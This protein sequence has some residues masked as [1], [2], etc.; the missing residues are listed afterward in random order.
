MDDLKMV[1]AD[2][3]Y[4]R[5]YL[6]TELGCLAST[7]SILKACPD[8]WEVPF[9]TLVEEHEGWATLRTQAQEC[10]SVMS[11]NLAAWERMNIDS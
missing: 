11:F 1:L 8:I 9:A 3:R 5:R 7:L 2:E 6:P 10:L 4:Q